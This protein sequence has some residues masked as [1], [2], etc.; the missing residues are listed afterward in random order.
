MKRFFKWTAGIFGGLIALLVF[1]GV[2]LYGIG[3]KQIKRSYPNIA[4]ETITIPN[5]SVAIA[6]GQHLSIIW[7]CTRCHGDNLAGKIISRERVSLMGGRIPASNLTS[8]KGGI[9]KFYN[10]TDWVRAIRHGVKPNGQ[11]EI[12]MYNY[13]AMS[14]RDLGDL[15]AFLKQIPPVDAEY[16]SIRFGPI[17]PISAALGIFKPAAGSIDH[18]ARHVAHPLPAATEEYGKYLFTGC[19]GCHGEGVTTPLRGKWSQEDFVHIIRTGVS[20]NGKRI[21]KAMPVSTYAEMS[22]TELAALWL[23]LRNQ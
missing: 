23:Y 20:S 16:P 6:H 21:D 18:N 14:D 22:D 11:G 17:L 8:G 1:V 12:F 5:D 4:V 19:A 13:S 15:I 3:M 10:E 7:A 9:A 2:V